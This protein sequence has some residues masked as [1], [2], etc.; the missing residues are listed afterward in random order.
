MK[1]YPDEEECM[2]LLQ[3]YGTPAH[4]IGHCRAV[5]D[6]AVNT[7]RRL[8]EVGFDLDIGLVRAAGL[9]HDIARVEKDHAKVAADYIRELGY[10]EVAD[11]V[12][13]HMFYPG[14]SPAE[15][16]NETDL[17]CLGDRTVRED[18]YVGAEERM[19]YIK[20]KAR[21]NAGD[22]LPE[23]LARLEVKKKELKEYV[24]RLEELMGVTLDE[25]NGKT[26]NDRAP[27]EAAQKS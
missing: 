18:Q 14:F 4:V 15:K 16:T 9:L 6:V 26:G 7:G 1:R 5:A 24:A 3:E 10:P 25:L 17:V 12:A 13:V 23:V 22:A 19:E 2:R 21:R 11:I 8:N 27:R 20:D